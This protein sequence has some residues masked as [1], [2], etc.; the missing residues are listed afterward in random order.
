M[1]PPTAPGLVLWADMLGVQAGDRVR[2]RIVGPD[3]GTVLDKEER[4]GRTQARRFLFAG[5]R[6]RA[7]VWSP[8]AYV[9]HVTLMRALDGQQVERSVTRTVTIR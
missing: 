8:G 5:Q 2:F 3:G 1:L 9:G 4:L 6:R 7:D